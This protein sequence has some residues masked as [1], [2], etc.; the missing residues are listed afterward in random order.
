MLITWCKPDFRLFIF[1]NYIFVAS[2]N[3]PYIVCTEVKK[4][5]LLSHYLRD[6][7]LPQYLALLD[8][9]NIVHHYVIFYHFLA[10][11]NKGAVCKVYLQLILSSY[12]FHSPIFVFLSSLFFHFCSY[13][14]VFVNMHI[15]IRHL[16]LCTQTIL[17]SARLF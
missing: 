1:E 12:I 10:G 5:N 17:L 9:S 4:L 16:P 14:A 7:L 6:I 3:V 13:S 15:I 2:L 11:S 8:T